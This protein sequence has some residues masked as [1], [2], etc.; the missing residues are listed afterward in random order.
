VL[1]ALMAERQVAPLTAEQEARLAAREVARQVVL[2]VL[3]AEREAQPPL[4]AEQEARRA[5]PG[6]AQQVVLLVLTVV[7]EAQPQPTVEQQAAM[8]TAELRAAQALMVAREEQ[9][10]RITPARRVPELLTIPAAEGQ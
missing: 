6:A 5:A 4:T 9:L 2:L 10:A 8:H 3:M 1:L 7:R